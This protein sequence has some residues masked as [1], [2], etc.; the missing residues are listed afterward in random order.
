MDGHDFEF[1]KFEITETIYVRLGSA[2]PMF[3]KRTTPQDRHSTL[4]TFIWAKISF[5]PT[6]DRRSFRSEKPLRFTLRFLHTGQRS[7]SGFGET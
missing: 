6:D 5:G 3:I 7:K 4:G 2:M 1:E